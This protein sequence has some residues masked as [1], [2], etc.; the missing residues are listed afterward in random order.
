MLSVLLNLSAAPKK[1]GPFTSKHHHTV[2][3]TAAPHAI[4]FVL[5]AQHVVEDAG[6][7][8]FRHALDEEQRR[9]HDT[10]LIAVVRSTSTVMKNVESMTTVSLRVVLTTRSIN[11]TSLIHKR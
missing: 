7:A 10:H 8:D 11:R 1:K 6:L 4:L 2:G 5:F 3:D 9:E